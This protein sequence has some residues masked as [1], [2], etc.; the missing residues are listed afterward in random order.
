MTKKRQNLNILGDGGEGDEYVKSIMERHYGKFMVMVTSLKCESNCTFFVIYLVLS[1]F[2][3]LHV[4]VLGSVL[5]C[6]WYCYYD[7]LTFCMLCVSVAAAGK[8]I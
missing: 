7:A 2:L 3:L 6:L 8:F 1:V 5:S 4:I